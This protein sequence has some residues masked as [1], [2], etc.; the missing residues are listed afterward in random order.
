MTPDGAGGRAVRVIMVVA[1]SLLAVLGTPGPAGAH[2]IVLSIDPADGATVETAP[3]TITVAFDEAIDV[4]DGAVTLLDDTGAAIAVDVETVG[5]TL[6]ISPRVGLGEGTFVVSWRVI[7]ADSH[8]VAGGS[9][10]HVGA[11]S[12]DDVSINDLGSP[13]G[14]GVLRG[15]ADGLVYAGALTAIGACWFARR[16]SSTSVARVA[17]TGAAVA[18]G[19]L[20]VAVAGRVGEFEASWSAMFDGEAWRGTL[21][22]ATGLL[23]LLTLGGLVLLVATSATSRFGVVAWTAGAVLVIAGLVAEG[24]TR[25]AEPG[26]LA[27]LAGV[28]H[29]GA[30]AA[31]LGGVAAL[32]AVWRSSDPAR[33]R[34]AAIDV[35]SAAIR[36]VAVVGVGG[37]VLAATVAPDLGAQIWSRWG[38]MVLVKVTLVAALVA[39]GW[40]NRRFLLPGLAAPDGQADRS[41]TLLGRTL[42]CEL[43][44][45]A[46]V[47]AATATLV[48]SPPSSGATGA[49]NPTDDRPGDVVS[50]R[51]ALS[52]GV[53]TAHFELSPGT[54]GANELVVTFDDLDG[55]PL[56]LIWDPIIEATAPDLGVGPLEL[57]PEELDGG[58]YRAVV[59]LAIPGRW[60]ITVQAR[61]GTF[62]SGRASIEVTV[63]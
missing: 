17:R 25:S 18:L 24:H 8:A 21:D 42:R 1:L 14:L 12:L 55:R 57:L 6:R 51:V 9:V 23:L 54:V 2:A 16:W 13:T 53:G 30:G 7:S 31:W 43:V 47:L 37:V 32:A 49:G 5:A 4:R 45:F 44:L 10:F 27:G 35:S 20:V 62:E 63:G 36:A 40:Y 41:A 59:D 58:S 52:S 15:V 61:T 28:A 29:I 3:T 56:E 38:M 33:R 26:W 19:A 34:A 46:A 60:E 39:L 11:A 48:S 22:G 50:E